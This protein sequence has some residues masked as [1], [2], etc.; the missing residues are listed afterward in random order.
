MRYYQFKGSLFCFSPPNLG[1][2][3]KV[4]NRREKK[5]MGHEA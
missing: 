1:E 4:M 3:R 2:G 5:V